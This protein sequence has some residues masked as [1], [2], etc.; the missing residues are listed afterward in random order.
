MV[1]QFSGGT[2]SFRSEREVGKLYTIRFISLVSSF[3]SR[4]VARFLTWRRQCINAVF[5]EVNKWQGDHE[6][7]C[8]WCT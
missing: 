4:K 5:V 3:L 8:C 1:Q 6:R 2:L 7:K